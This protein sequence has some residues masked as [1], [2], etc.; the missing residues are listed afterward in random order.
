MNFIGTYTS[1]SCLHRIIFVVIVEVI[2]IFLV[3]IRKPVIKRRIYL[4]P[5]EVQESSLRSD[6]SHTWIS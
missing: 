1:N 2:Q 3:H 5:S 4:L 6:R